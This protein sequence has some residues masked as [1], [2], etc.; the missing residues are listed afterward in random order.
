MN[1]GKSGTKDFFLFFSF[2]VCCT[3]EIEAVL[4]SEMSVDSYQTALP[5]IGE[6]DLL[7]AYV[8]F[9]QAGRMKSRS[10]VL[11][12]VDRSLCSKSWLSN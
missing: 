3:I 1:T 10:T 2:V 4:S 12:T 7:E 5:H 11:I 6:H 9:T 8:G